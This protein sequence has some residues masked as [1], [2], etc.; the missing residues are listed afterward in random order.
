MR[1]H[2]E[3]NSNKLMNCSHDS[4]FERQAVLFS[5]K[6]ISL[7]EGIAT[8]NTNSHEIDN[9]SEMTVTPF[10]DSACTFKLTQLKDRWV[11]ASIGNRGLMQGEVRDI[12]YFSKE[13]GC[14]GIPDTVNRSN[15][16]H[17]LNSDRLAE[18]REDDRELI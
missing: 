6:E 11:N 16:L 10:R 3:N 13:G 9:P 2:S 14:C 18:L 12:S 15:D 1:K 17:I 8:D 7:K 5:F 4:L